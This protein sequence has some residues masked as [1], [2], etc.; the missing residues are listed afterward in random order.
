[1]SRFRKERGMLSL[2]L[3]RHPLPATRIG[4]RHVR[5]RAVAFGRRNDG[6]R[7]GGGERVA[8]RRRDLA[9]R[10]R[11]RVGRRDARRKGRRRNGIWDDRLIARYDGNTVGVIE[12]ELGRLQR[13]V[14]FVRRSLSGRRGERMERG[15]Q[16][17]LSGSGRW[18]SRR[19][20]G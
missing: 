13:S 6:R 20:L 12:L 17:G 2:R 15:L 18:R 9:R 4:F 7:N 14:D 1:M 10:A 19:G 5:R 11:R 3:R 8:L 16:E